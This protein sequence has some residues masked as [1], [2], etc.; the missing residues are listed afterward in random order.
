ML[1]NSQA[2]VVASL[3]WSRTDGNYGELLERRLRRHGVNAQVINEARLWDLLHNLR[4]RLVESIGCHCPDVVV[5]GYGMGECESNIPPTWLM[6]IID[7]GRW[8]PSLNPFATRVRKM[9]LPLLLKFRSWSQRRLIP[10]FG[11][12]LWRLRPSRFEAELERMIRFTR[13]QTGARVIV[14]SLYDPGPNLETAIPTIRKRAERYNQII[15][16][17]VAR[18]DERDV[19]VADIWTPINTLGWEKATLEGLH[20]TATGHAAIAETLEEAVLGFIA[21]GEHAERPHEVPP[22]EERAARMDAI[23]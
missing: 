7:F 18:F 16:D 17:V 3:H 15:R 1:G 14:L 22:E 9:F 23:G 8:I 10:I 19:R 11:K 4:P 13:S 2:L 6:K 12:H 5:F 21:T 20:Y